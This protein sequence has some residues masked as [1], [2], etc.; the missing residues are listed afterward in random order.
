V[1]NDLCHSIPIAHQIQRIHEKQFTA[2]V[3]PGDIHRGQAFL[4]L[5]DLVEVLML[6]VEKRRHLPQVTS[7]VMGEPET[8]SYDE[9]QRLIS[10]HLHGREWRTFRIPKPLAKMGAWLQD[11][12][13]GPEPFIKPWMI[14]LADDHYAL[15]VSRARDLLGWEPR[16]SLRE[17]LPKMLEALQDDPARW[18]KENKLKPPRGRTG[19][20]WPHTANI[21]LGLWLIGTA[22]A[23]GPISPA[24]LWSDVISGGLCMLF[25][26]LALRWT[27]AAWIT[28]GIGLWVMSAPLIFW[29]RNAAV[30]NNDMLAGALIVTFA[31]I[32]PYLGRESTPPGNPPGWSYNPSSWVQRLGIVFLALIGFLLSRYMA[33]FQLGHI[34]HPWDPFFG[35]GTRRVLTSD[36]SR[37]FPVSDAGLGA[38]SYLMDALAGLIGGERRWRRMPWIVLLFGIFIIPPGV[39]SIVLVILQPVGVG[40]WCTLCLAASVVMLMM[41]P[42]ALDEVIA[43]SQ[44]LRRTRQQGGSLWR[45]LW[46]GEGGMEEDPRAKPAR[47]SWKELVHGIEVFSAPWNLLLATIIGIWI[48]AAPTL[49]GLTGATA[50]VTHIMGALVVTLAVVAYAEPTRAVRFLNM[51]IGVWLL[52]TPWLA[53]GSSP[54]W[55]WG[56]V[57]TGIALIALSFPRGP[58]DDRYGTWQKWIR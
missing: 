10:R 49:A 30:Y 33:A 21:F 5:E 42:P 2:R 45:A 48:M 40:E 19:P 7:L 3:F 11:A 47:S 54:L 35:N 6:L 23:L 4:H 57:M 29:A 12:M 55:L 32:V 50:D 38:L 1:Y 58:V 34:P 56:G 43:T 41:V 31:G 39:T 18:Y 24:L 44:F 20:A 22:P 37:A 36:I 52:L 51:P 46:R 27:W 14:D 53:R 25:A 17:T 13:P 9:L 26:A 16:H 28:C 15:D 8:L